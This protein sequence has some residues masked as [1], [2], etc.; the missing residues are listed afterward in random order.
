MWSSLN[1]RSICG[2]QYME[3]YFQWACFSHMSHHGMWTHSI[4]WGEALLWRGTL[5]KFIISQRVENRSFNQSF[6]S[7]RKVQTIDL[8]SQSL[9]FGHGLKM[10]SWRRPKSMRSYPT[11]SISPVNL[12]AHFIR[13]EQNRSCVFNPVVA[14]DNWYLIWIKV[15]SAALLLGWSDCHS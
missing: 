10:D 6:Q 12:L 13:T 8:F 3:N 9:R 15:Q 2:C 14:A 11:W 1:T 7:G 4:R 5:M